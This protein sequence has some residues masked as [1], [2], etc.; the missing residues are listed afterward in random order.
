MRIGC[1]DR[2]CASAEVDRLFQEK[3]F[4]LPQISQG[5]IDKIE[6]RYIELGHLKDV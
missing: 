6:K 4:D 3:Y 5:T 2:S 1:G